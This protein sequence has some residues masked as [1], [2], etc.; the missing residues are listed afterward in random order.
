MKD[1]LSLKAG[2]SVI[3]DGEEYECVYNYGNGQY[4]IKQ[5]D[6]LYKVKLVS[7]GEII[8]KEG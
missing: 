8:K 3:H 2:E 1:E 5:K 6:A 7:K 4:E